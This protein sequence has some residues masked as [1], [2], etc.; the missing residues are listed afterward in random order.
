MYRRHQG[1]ES[2]TPTEGIPSKTL[3]MQM[4]LGTPRLRKVMDRR[5]P[6]YTVQGNFP[7]N[8]EYKRERAARHHAMLT[9]F[10]EKFAADPE[11]H[12]VSDV[13]SELLIDRS[14]PAPLT[15]KRQLP[16]FKIAFLFPHRIEPNCTVGQDEDMIA[17]F[18]RD[19][20]TVTVVHDV[21]KS[22][23]FDQPKQEKTPKAWIFNR[24]FHQFNCAACD[25]FHFR[26]GIT[27]DGQYY[28]PAIMTQLCIF[29]HVRFIVA[30]SVEDL[31]MFLKTGTKF[32]VLPTFRDSGDATVED[33]P[34]YGLHINPTI[35]DEDTHGDAGRNEIDTR[36]PPVE[37]TGWFH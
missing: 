17:K 10:K 33:A 19:L 31:N 30:P 22:L 2:S 5:L 18:P 21:I 16:G 15:L 11:F 37:Y 28:M 27:A 20:P 1:A 7:S 6:N 8:D 25:F 36:V 34:S 13:L 3:F 26:F 35:D 4:Y 24:R 29:A 14:G 9:R 32:C 12:A 23:R